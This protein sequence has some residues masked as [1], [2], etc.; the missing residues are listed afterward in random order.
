MAQEDI[1]PSF[2]LKYFA[3]TIISTVLISG[4]GLAISKAYE[5]KQKREIEVIQDEEIDILN[6]SAFP[7]DHIEA[8]YHLKGNPK[9][10]VATLFRKVV[11]IRNAGSEGAENILV[12]AALAETEAH[13]VAA[14][15]IRTQPKEIVDA[16][17]ISK[18]DSSAA[19]KQTWNIS[20]LN[21]GE[22]VIFEYF[23]YSE[24]KLSSIK[25]TILPRKKD[26]TV[27]NKSILGQA[28]NTKETL[29][30]SLTVVGGAPLA[31]LLLVYVIAVPFY[32]YQWNR[33][34]DYR[35]KYG[36]FNAFYNRHR[37]WNLFAPPLPESNSANP[38]V[39]TDAAR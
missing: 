35:E 2:S 5:S 15:K 6:D 18:G 29:I 16:I 10:K 11:V 20:L 28:P 4:I 13:L 12:S 38:A 31:L 22:S 3:L 19:N 21:P 37:P 26:W 36:S 7:R 23:V 1:K 24:Q 33:R 25:L 39:H 8:T 34:P 32:R 14:P 30:R 17:A 27:V 9:K